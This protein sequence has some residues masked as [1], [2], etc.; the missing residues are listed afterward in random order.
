MPTPAKPTLHLLG[1]IAIDGIASDAADRLLSQTKVV[2]FLAFLSL[3]PDG[4]LQRRDKLAALLWPELDQEHARAALRKVVLITR[5]E[6]GADALPRRGDEDLLLNREFLGCD[7]TRFL[8]LAE[9]GQVA[10]ALELYHGELLPGFHIPDCADF[11]LWLDAERAALSERAS[12]AAWTLALN[13]EASKQLTEAGKKARDAIRFEWSNERVLRRT[14]LML[15]RIGD[16]TGALKAF[17][18]SSRRMR[19]ELETEPSEETVRL[20]AA[21]R[22]GETVG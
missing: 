12:A 22:K 15:V 2:G 19:A 1:G 21:I 8:E 16:R 13:L 3:A 11:G 14:M 10:P 6:I 17:E 9:A 20:A 4:R 18:D 7:A 5:K